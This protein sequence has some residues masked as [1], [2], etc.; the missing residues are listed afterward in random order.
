MAFY[1][2]K[3]SNK[4]ISFGTHGS[5][6]RNSPLLLEDCPANLREEASDSTNYFKIKFGKDKCVHPAPNQT[7]LLLGT[8]DGDNTIFSKYISDSNMNEDNDKNFVFV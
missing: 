1:K 2:H 6:I 8:C 4:C 5:Y 3:E 7:D